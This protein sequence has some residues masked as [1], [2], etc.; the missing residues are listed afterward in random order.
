MLLQKVRIL[1]ADNQP[2]IRRGL[3][4]LLQEE[5]NLSVVGEVSK[6]CQIISA[7]K[8]S[9]PHLLLLELN[10]FE[11]PDI[12]NLIKKMLRECHLLKIVIL[13]DHHND[14]VICTLINQLTQKGEN[15]QSQD[16]QNEYSQASDFLTLE[17]KGALLR[18]QLFTSCDLYQSFQRLLESLPPTIAVEMSVMPASVRFD[19]IASLSLYGIVSEAVS[20]IKKHAEASQAEIRLD[21]LPS[22]ILLFIQDD[23]RGFD[24]TQITNQSR[25]LNQ[26]RS[27]VS[28]LGGTV[29][30]GDGTR[31]CDMDERYLWRAAVRK[32]WE[33]AFIIRH[34][35]MDERYLWLW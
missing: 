15:E 24:P 8:K 18:S 19:A 27:Y 30:I 28:L 2:L 14:D 21:V 5:T 22:M 31:D 32:N 9:E 25:G 20:N 35:D 1:I 17:I 10:L 3:R 6:A 12:T 7:I 11:L 26:I 23:G 4:D 16:E 33:A 34:C 13:T 29:E